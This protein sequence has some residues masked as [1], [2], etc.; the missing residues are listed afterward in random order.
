MSLP[1]LQNHKVIIVIGIPGA[2]KTT[3]ASKLAE[4]FSMPIISHDLMFKNTDLSSEDARSISEAM[5][6]EILKTGASVVFDSPQ[7][8]RTQRE[9]LVKTIAKS[10]YSPLLVWVQTETSEAKRRAFRNDL[11]ADQFDSL[12]GKFATPKAKDKTAVISGKHTYSSQVKIVLKHLARKPAATKDISAVRQ[13]R[14]GASAR[15]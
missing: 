3:F 12:S 7:T 11:A 10:G 6:T 1:S 5:L 2:G 8:T 4:T 9:A 15:R 14:I 13:G